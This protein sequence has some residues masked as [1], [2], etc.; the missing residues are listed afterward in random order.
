VLTKYECIKILRQPIT[1]FFAII[2]P[3]GWMIFNGTMYTNEPSKLFHDIGT[4]DY[5]FSSLVFIVVLVNGLSNIPLLIARNIEA[6]IY[7]RFAA[8]PLRKSEY[9][10]SLFLSN[11]LLVYSSTVILF[12]TGYF[13]Y[14]INLPENPLAFVFYLGIVACSVEAIGILIATHIKGFNNVLSLSFLLYFSMLFLSG[15]SVPLEV[16]PDIFT[17]LAAYNVFAHYIDVK[18]SFWISAIDINLMTVMWTTI[19]AVLFIVLSVKTFK[20]G[21]M[22]S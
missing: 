15:A 7:M 19:I 21:E 11:L 16:L 1:V 20:W 4:L 13:M 9:I 8:S 3:I 17:D 5:I 18:K 14:G 12:F 6:K 10:G 22:R 2:F